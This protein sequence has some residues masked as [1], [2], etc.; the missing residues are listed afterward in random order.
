MF[1]G[2]VFCVRNSEKMTENRK[3]FHTY[4]NGIFFVFLYIQLAS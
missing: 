3:K 2:S 4:S 1:S